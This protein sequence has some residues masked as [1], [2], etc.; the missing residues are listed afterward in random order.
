MH[1]SRRR[2]R[3]SVTFFSARKLQRVYV[4]GISR[5]FNFFCSSVVYTQFSTGSENLTL[6]VV[7]HLLSHKILITGI[8]IN[9]IGKIIYKRAKCHGKLLGLPI[10]TCIKLIGCFGTK[11]R[12]AFLVTVIMIIHTIRGKFLRVGHS[13]TFACIDF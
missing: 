2:K 12:I 8:K 10:E 7:K 1:I 13:E 11:R 6:T 5:K 4:F 3:Q 9:V